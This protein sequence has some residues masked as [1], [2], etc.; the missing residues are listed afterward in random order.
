MSRNPKD[1]YKTLTEIRERI[2]EL[3]EEGVRHS[4][5]PVGDIAAE[6]GGQQLLADMLDMEDSVVIVLEIPGVEKKDIDI[7]LVGNDLLV[8]GEKHHGPVEAVTVYH[9]AERFY[10]PFQRRIRLPEPVKQSEIS[11]NLDNGLLEIKIKKTKPKQIP[12]T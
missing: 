8:K 2:N 4:Q 6:R 10:G 9:M 11:T 12:I 7:Q 1:P 5:N 3:F